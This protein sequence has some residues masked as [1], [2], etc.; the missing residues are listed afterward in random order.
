V[1][2]PDNYRKGDKLPVIIPNSGYQG[3]NEFYPK[4]FSR[5][6]TK[7]GFACLGFDYRGFGKSEGVEGRLVLEEQVQDIKNAITCAQIQ[8]EMD[9]DR[10]GLIGWG[11]G[12]LNVVTL[13]STEK[14]AKAVAALNGFYNG[15][16]WLKTIHPYH[17]WNELLEMI[18]K[19]RIQRVKTGKSRKVDP[20]ISYPLDPD[21]KAYVDKELASVGNFGERKDL[22]F[23]DSILD[24]DADRL[25][26]SISP[27]PLFIA[28]GNKNMLHPRDEAEAL[29]ASASTPKTMYWI[30]GKHNDFM[31]YDHPE[32]NK[33]MKAL[34]EFFQVL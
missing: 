27:R 12:A 28:H 29:Y 13:A 4:L 17:K 15:K 5:Y 26:A 20:F 30:E 6:L 9:P 21:T 8:D 19:D 24:I 14:R 22:Q 3:F 33:L 18:E 10:I 11:M 23:T 2:L 7:A 1:Y 31:Y 25:A 34:V 32:L 16:R